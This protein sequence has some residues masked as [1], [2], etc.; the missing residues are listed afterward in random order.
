MLAQYAPPSYG[1]GYVYSAGAKAVGIFCG[2][3]PILLMLVFGSVT[4]WKMKGTISEVYFYHITSKLK[5]INDGEICKISQ[6][7][8][9]KEFY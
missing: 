4:I 7:E 6:K 2:L 9:Y 5:I 3:L 1:D 8:S